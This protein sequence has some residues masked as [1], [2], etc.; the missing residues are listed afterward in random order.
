MLRIGLYRKPGNFFR[1]SGHRS[2]TI[3]AT[4]NAFKRRNALPQVFDFLIVFSQVS[5]FHPQGG[6]RPPCVCD[7]LQKG[8][9]CPPYNNANKLEFKTIQSHIKYQHAFG[10]IGVWDTVVSVTGTHQGQTFFPTGD[11][12][13]ERKHGFF[14]SGNGAIK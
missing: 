8:G 9:R 11:Q 13:I 3:M 12:T 2:T 7:Y 10:A 14:A 5:P 6:Q 4:H 1:R